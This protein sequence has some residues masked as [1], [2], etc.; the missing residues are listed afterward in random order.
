MIE[1][2]VAAGV[3]VH[4]HER[5][6]AVKIV[7]LDSAVLDEALVK[8]AYAESYSAGSTEELG[9]VVVAVLRT[10]VE[11]LVVVLERASANLNVGGVDELALVSGAGL[12]GEHL[13]S[14]ISAACLAC[15]KGGDVIVFNGAVI[16]LCNC[17]SLCDAACIYK[18]EYVCARVGVEVA[19]VDVHLAAGVPLHCGAVILKA[20]HLDNCVADVGSL[21]VAVKVS[22]VRNEGTTAAHA[23]YSTHDRLGNAG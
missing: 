12:I 9:V 6:V 19:A 10:H 13:L 4:K 20:G 8:G 22:A 1:S 21:T 11:E 16:V 17:L 7:D 14:L 23:H 5:A 3:V 15:V 2:A 18:I